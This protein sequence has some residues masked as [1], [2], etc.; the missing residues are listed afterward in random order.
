MLFVV[1]VCA[2]QGLLLGQ[3]NKEVEPP[4]ALILSLDGQEHVLETNAEKPIEGE[5]TNP[6]AKIRLAGYRVFRQKGISFR[7]PQGMDFDYEHANGAD[8]WD[9]IGDD[10]ELS[11]YATKG[12]PATFLKSA[13]DIIVSVTEKPNQT[14][15]LIKGKK[16]IRGVYLDTYTYSIDWGDSDTI[17][18]W[19]IA[20]PGKNETKILEFV[21]EFKDKKLVKECAD[22]ENM[23]LKSLQ[24]IEYKQ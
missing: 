24:W 18:V 14:V 12:D 5:F 15:Q 2:P 22:L 7:Y 13:I 9:L 8:S 3:D 23:V 11:I 21:R 17:D 20:I 4:L 6:K 10:A 1:A 16:K 19:A